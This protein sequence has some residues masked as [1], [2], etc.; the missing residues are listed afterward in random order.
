MFEKQGIPC[1]SQEAGKWPERQTHNTQQ[2][3]SNASW[4]DE[5]E[6]PR[7]PSPLNLEFPD[8]SDILGMVLPPRSPPFRWCHVLFLVRPI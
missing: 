3:S 1:A 5:S 8:F 7:L 2:T 6:L 4:Q